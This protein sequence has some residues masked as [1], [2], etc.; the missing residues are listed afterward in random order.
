MID[1]IPAAGPNPPRAAFFKEMAAAM[2]FL[3]LYH[4]LSA[5]EQDEV[6][7]TLHSF[8]VPVQPDKKE[9]RK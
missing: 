8:A 3:A 6:I 2:Q 5:E 1:R 7:N 4:T 9:K